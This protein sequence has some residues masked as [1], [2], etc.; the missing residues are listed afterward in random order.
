MSYIKKFNESTNIE[1]L[2]TET[3]YDWMNN[4][5]KD[6]QRIKDG[7]WDISDFEFINPEFPYT[8][9]YVGNKDGKSIYEDL[10]NKEK[11]ESDFL[12]SIKEFVTKYPNFGI[13]KPYQTDSVLWISGIP[14]KQVKTIGSGFNY[15]SNNIIDNCPKK[16]LICAEND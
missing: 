12:D 2:T 14:T 8:Q 13:A 7:V 11:I 3:F 9:K 10:P 4:I 1:D 15:G 6:K 5:E 16:I